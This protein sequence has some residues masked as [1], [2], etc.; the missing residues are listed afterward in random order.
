MPKKLIKP[1]YEKAG[2]TIYHGDCLKILP[3]IEKVDLVL[4]DPPYGIN[5]D[6]DYARRIKGGIKYEKIKGDNKIFDVEKYRKFINANIEIWFGAECYWVSHDLECSWLCWDKYATDKNDKRIAGS[7]EL[8]R[9]SKK[10][11]RKK[12]IIPA[13]NTNW[14]TVKERVGHPDSGY[15]SKL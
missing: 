4:T 12:Y 3:K 15:R 10:V 6:T 2:I 9:I 1:Y 7:F 8:A 14:N 11:K 13:I 5:K